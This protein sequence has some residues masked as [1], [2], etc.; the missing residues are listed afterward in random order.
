[1]STIVVAVVGRKGGGGKT[2][3]AANLAAALARTEAVVLVDADP[4]G[5]LVSLLPG[6]DRLR[7]VAARTEEVLE[8]ELDRARGLV[9]VDTP[10]VLVGPA[11]LAV[12]RAALVVV[13]VCPSVV[14]LL[15]AAPLV[16]SLRKAG[17]PA[18]V[19]LTQVR[20]GTRAAATAREAVAALG[21]P[22][23][24]AELRH[25][26]I[27]S[28]SLA[29]GRTAVDLAPGGPAAAEVRSIASEVRRLLRKGTR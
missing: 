15:S 12:G 7:V 11:A 19:V 20:A 14:D 9:V 1:M 27:Y 21:L 17:K 23:A 26:V 3:L 18:L 5:S 4:S 22:V 10:P 6:G 24:R 28:D 25:R 2:T 13:P 16:E 8:R 29:A